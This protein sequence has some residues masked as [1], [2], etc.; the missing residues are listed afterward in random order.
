MS[1][2]ENYFGKITEICQT[3]SGYEKKCQMAQDKHGLILDE[4]DGGLLYEGEFFYHK[5]SDKMFY[6][7]LDEGEYSNLIRMADDKS[8]QSFVINLIFYNGGACFSEALEKLLDDTIGDG[9]DGT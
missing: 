4:E 2:T 6:L 1:R 8:G 7:E 3:V 9:G 5:M